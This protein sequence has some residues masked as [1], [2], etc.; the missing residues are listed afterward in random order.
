MT[1]IPDITV[2]IPARNAAATL[3]DALGSLQAQTLQQWEAIVVDDGSTDDTAASA[4]AMGLSDPRIR[5]LRQPHRG[6][7]EARNAGIEEARGE[8]L[9]FLDADDWIDPKHLKTLWAARQGVGLVHCGWVRVMPDGRRGRPCFGPSDEDLIQVMAQYCPF[10]IHACLVRRDAVQRAG[11][12]DP[13]LVTC[14]DWDL[15]QRIVRQGGRFRTVHEILAFY[16]TQPGSASTAMVRLLADGLTIIG[17]GHRPDPQEGAAA[18]PPVDISFSAAEVSARY[19]FSIWVG[20]YGIGQ[21]HETAPWMEHLRSTPAPDLSPD[22]V[23]AALFDSLPLGAATEV[24]NWEARW[25]DWLPPVIRLLE[26][27]EDSSKVPGLAMR[28]RRLLERRI[29]AEMPHDR[30]ARIGLIAR[31]LFDA[32]SPGIARPLPE[33]V[34]RLLVSVMHRGHMISEIQWPVADAQSLAAL[35]QTCARMCRWHRLRRPI[36]WLRR[37]GLGGPLARARVAARWVRGWRHGVCALLRATLG[38]VTAAL[39]AP[40][41]REASTT[42]PELAQS[43]LWEQIFA[44]PD[45][46][47]YGNDYERR[48]YEQTLDLL[49]PEPIGCALELACAEGHFTCQLAPRV[50]HLTAVDISLTALGRA[51]ARCRGLSSI[52]FVQVDLVRDAIPAGN[53]LIVCSEVLY[54]LQD[55][56]ALRAV[57][58]KIADALAPGGCLVMAHAYLVHDEP[59]RTGFRWRQPFG[60]KVIGDVFAATAPLV[61]EREIRTP[62]YRVQMFRRPAAPYAPVR[63]AEIREE[64][65]GNPLP[66][67]VARQVRWCR[68]G[69]VPAV[70]GFT[71]QLP[72]LMYHQIATDGPASLA[73]YRVHPQRFDEQLGLL[74]Q[75]GYHALS[76][77]RWREHMAT[78]RPLPGRPVLITFDDGYQNVLTE[79]W[80]ILE[81][82]GM[83]A[84]VFV[85]AD[86]IGDRAGWDAHYG[87]AAP[88]MSWDEIHWLQDRGIE[89]GAHGATHRPFTALTTAELTNELTRSRLLLEQGLGEAVTALAYPYGEHDEVVIRVAQSCGFDCAFTTR[90]GI[91]VVGGDRLQHPR[92]EVCGTDDLTAFAAKLGLL[93]GA[94]YDQEGLSA[95]A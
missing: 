69:M 34:D 78:G 10:A 88:L 57:A 80:P 81:R 13:E 71:R 36:R 14:E 92:I 1:R 79:A 49:P 89:F 43:E 17:R 4:E 35:E 54:Y 29:L 23:A 95:A 28:A 22:A 65:T 83:T 2:V 56:T 75:H 38:R 15:W 21:G 59:D 60:A 6:V 93:A 86:A 12:F 19:R 26:A 9:L 53:D 82:H 61:L 16:R 30:S 3:R 46:W 76:L 8:W 32:A 52:D 24:E 31:V 58:R 63:P 18:P 40:P 94:G 84:S 25:N 44:T 90:N 51:R 64:A 39:T 67:E 5:V 41:A 87:P 11:G 48:K 74:R 91:A 37:Y 55:L 20:G 77:D 45:P 62:L 27:V 70:P 47:D 73:R 42:P 7:S 66:H 72:I 68:P 85:V 50:R 33:N